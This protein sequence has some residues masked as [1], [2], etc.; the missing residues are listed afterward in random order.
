MVGLSTLDGLRGIVAA[1]VCAGVV[2]WAAGPALADD[3]TNPSYPGSTLH[4]TVNQV[5]ATEAIV[6]ATGTNVPLMLEGQ[7][8]LN[9]FQLQLFEDNETLL[10]FPCYQDYGDELNT[11][12]N[13]DLA[14]RFLTQ[15]TA[16]EGDGGPFTISLPVPLYA[17]G[18]LR[19][20]VY[21]SDNFTDT[22][23]WSTA[24][25]TVASASQGANAKPVALSR[26]RVRR[27]GRLLRCSPGRWS[28]SPASYK[29]RWA[30][31]HRAGVAGR[32]AGLAVTRELHDHNVECSVSA[33]NS[34][35]ST[36]ATSPPFKV[37]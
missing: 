14:V 25:I 13:N 24:D 30:V 23:A 32:N 28:G 27:S 15:G 31:V 17:T 3:G 35:G 11:A 33:R 6:T 29:Y 36:T 12:V 21:N 37:A 1:C 34:A 22:T 9:D 18:P 4:I 2:A 8:T 20:C 26:P 10:P 5:A 7:P 19:F 16:S